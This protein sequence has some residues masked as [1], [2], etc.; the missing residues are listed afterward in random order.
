MS[1]QEKNRIALEREI[2]A[3]RAIREAGHLEAQ[4]H[5]LRK[6]CFMLTCY[7]VAVLL[8]AVLSGY[9][10]QHEMEKLQRDFPKQAVR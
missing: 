3:E 10:Y 5:R 1:G 2:A 7:L 8:A 4:C 9:H 6:R